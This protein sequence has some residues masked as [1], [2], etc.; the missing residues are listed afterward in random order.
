MLDATEATF[1]MSSRIILMRSSLIVFPTILG[2]IGVRK[3]LRTPLTLVVYPD[4]ALCSPVV[5]ATAGSSHGDNPSG[6]L[7]S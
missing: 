6:L 3:S 2:S 7:E 1:D 5:G 4:T